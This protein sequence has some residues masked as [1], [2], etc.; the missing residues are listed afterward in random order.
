MICYNIFHNIFHL[1]IFPELSRYSSLKTGG[2]PIWLT[3]LTSNP[4]CGWLYRHRPAPLSRY[5]LFRLQMA[6][7]SKTALRKPMSDITEVGHGQRRS[8]RNIVGCFMIKSLSWWMRVKVPCSNLEHHQNV[9]CALS[10]SIFTDNNTFPTNRQTKAD[11]HITSL[12]EVI[13]IINWYRW[14]FTKWS[15]VVLHIQHFSV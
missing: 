11:Y 12:A 6:M 10:L 8:V 13:I 7:S 2:V 3:C 15:Q 14:T 9:I 4:I 1:K 5:G